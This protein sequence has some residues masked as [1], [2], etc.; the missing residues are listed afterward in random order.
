MFLKTFGEVKSVKKQQEQ[1]HHVKI[2]ES[3]KM[4]G[5]IQTRGMIC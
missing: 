4:Y 2:L 1:I 5:I 3:E